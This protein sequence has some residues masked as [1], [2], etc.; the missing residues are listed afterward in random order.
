MSY[1]PAETPPNAAGA[2]HLRG[3]RMSV[4]IADLKRLRG[5]AGFDNFVAGGQD[6]DTRPAVNLDAF[7]ANHGERG[8]LRESHALSW[9][10]HRRTRRS[11][12]AA[13]AEILPGL[14]APPDAHPV[15]LPH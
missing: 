6:C 3:Q 13:R 4:R 11:L 15:A 7:A 1:F 14:N 12:A 8:N 5:L 9:R 10:E 2:G